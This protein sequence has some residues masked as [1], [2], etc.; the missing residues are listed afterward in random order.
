MA[1][2]AKAASTTVESGSL[3]AFM[4]TEGVAHGWLAALSLVHERLLGLSASRSTSSEATSLLIKTV[5]L[6]LRGLGWD[7]LRSAGMIGMVTGGY[8]LSSEKS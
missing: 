5:M 4:M 2:F 3:R 1:L 8:N 7:A 6:G